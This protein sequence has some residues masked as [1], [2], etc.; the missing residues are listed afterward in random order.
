MA[1][2]TFSP[3]F[4]ATYGAFQWLFQGSLTNSNAFLTKIS[5]QD[6]PSVS[7]NPQKINFGNQP[8]RI[9]STSG[10]RNSDQ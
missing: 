9:V 2:D 6:A 5:A 7:L 8:L 10:V 4:P 3:N 1:G